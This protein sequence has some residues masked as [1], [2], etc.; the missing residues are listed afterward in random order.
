MTLK[1]EIT[2]FEQAQDYLY[3][4]PRF[5]SKN[6]PK[7]TKQFLGVLGNPD[8]GLHIIHVAGTN[9]KG[10]VCAYLRSILEA[11]GRKTAAFTSPHLVD[12]R[13]RFVIGQERISK[14]AFLKVFLTVY[15]SLDWMALEQG[16]GYHPTYFEYL[17]LMAMLWF[18][19]EKPDVCILE[20]GLGGRLDATNSVTS[21]ELAIITR[22]GLDHVE[23][24][25]DTIKAIAGEKA[26]IMKTGVPLVFSDVEPEATCVFLEEAE[27]LGISV[28]GVSKNDYAKINFKN[29]FIDFY[30]RS[31]YYGYVTLSLHT[32][33]RYQVEN[34]A[35]AV[36][37][38]EVWD[39]EHNITQEQIRQ[40]LWNGTWPG[41]MEE[42]LPEVYV[43]GAH[44]EDGICAFLD[45]V[46][47]DGYDQRRCL[48][49]GVVADKDYSAMLQ[50]LI[51]AHA[52]R[53]IAVAHLHTNRAVTLEKIEKL[54]LQYPECEYTL[55][56]NVDTAFRALLAERLPEERIYIVGS[57][58]L[59]GEIKELLNHD[60]F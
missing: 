24:L 53:F 17:F 42:I 51:K 18:S 1:K 30:M 8:Q 2:T 25:G 5:T 27:K 11:A 40:G 43:D 37:A 7:D 49:F 3:Q 4:V 60:K 44:N 31:L 14:E 28:Y 46:R 41:R 38:L 32:I 26:G 21:K 33:A 10:S 35:L 56:E 55:Y 16:K 9:G 19:E 15:N 12:I 57:L 58:Y 29:K 22:I 52:F 23:Y 59:A 39:R 45:T 34:A 6:S 20:T 36:R 54:L 48:M 47:Y 50:H 13:E